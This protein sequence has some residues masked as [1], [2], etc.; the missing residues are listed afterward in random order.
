MDRQKTPRHP[1]I[2]SRSKH[3]TSA[4][5]VL[6]VIA[7]HSGNNE[8]FSQGDVHCAQARGKGCLQAMQGRLVLTLTAVALM[9]GLPC[10]ALNEV[11]SSHHRPSGQ[12]E[13][14]E[15]VFSLKHKGDYSLGVR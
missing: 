13:R 15:P 7:E 2:V 8:R 12:T 14:L 10:M 3:P 11:L 6:T 9:I 5:K 4:G 1:A